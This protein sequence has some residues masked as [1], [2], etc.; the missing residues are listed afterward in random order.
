M[1]DESA[2]D[3]WDKVPWRARQDE[4]RPQRPARRHAPI[5]EGQD[6]DSMVAK[7]GRPYGVFEPGREHPYRGC[8]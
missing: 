3:Y 8:K 2:W 7:H 1:A 6:Y 5:P 4:S